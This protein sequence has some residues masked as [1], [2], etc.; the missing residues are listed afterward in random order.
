MAKDRSKG[1]RTPL[2]EED[3][4]LFERIFALVREGCP[5][6]D[7]CAAVGI[8][9]RTFYAWKKAGESADADPRLQ[10]FLQGLQRARAEGKAAMI[11]TIG[12]AGRGQPV[13]DKAGKIIGY[14]DG[15]WKAS[16]HLLACLD[17]EQFSIRR[18]HEHSGPEGGPIAVDLYDAVRL[19]ASEDPDEDAEDLGESVEGNSS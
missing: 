7:A 3:P 11:A 10:Q 19:P 18:R 1:G 8:A 4:E 12:R 17:P 15:D 14:S 16:A 9:E 5:Y 13:F 6:S 2:F